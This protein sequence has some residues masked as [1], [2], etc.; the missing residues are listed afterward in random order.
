MEGSSYDG[1]DIHVDP[2]AFCGVAARMLASGGRDSVPAVLTL[3]GQ[4]LRADVVLLEACS[5]RAAIPKP[6]VRRGAPE[7]IGLDSQAPLELPVRS[8]DAV[9]AVLSIEP[10]PGGL[11]AAWTTVAPDPLGTIADLLALSMS[12]RGVGAATDVESTSRAWFDLEESD[13][14][15][16]AG[17]LHDSLVQS[18]V[19]ARYLLDLATTTWPDGPLPWLDAV[20]ESLQAA[21]ADGR[22]LLSSVQSRTRSGRGLRVALEALCA[23]T[24]IPVQLQTVEAVQDGFLQIPRER[25]AVAYRFVQAGL[26]DLISRGADAAEVCAAFGPG[27]LSIDVVAIGDHPAWPDEPGAAMRRWG[28]RIELLGATVL[29][30]SASAHL[31]FGPAD[32]DPAL[33]R[34]VHAGRTL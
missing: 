30:Q 33:A 6:R 21:L 12:S 14:A 23:G 9:I 15:D 16:L 13:R 34:D 31:R 2:A 8:R 27:G 26:A 10:E 3:L 11:P 17:E 18:L 4:A 28:T 24:R 5:T 7:I 22:G 19:A 25:C 32:E 1:T 20:R 29:L